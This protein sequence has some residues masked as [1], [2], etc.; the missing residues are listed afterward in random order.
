VAL[1]PVHGYAIAPPQDLKT[2]KRNARERNRV[3]TVNQSFETLR[4]AVPSAAAHRKLSKVNIVQQAMEYIHSLVQLLQEAEMTSHGSPR[5]SGASSPTCLSSPV[6]CWSF[7]SS[8]PQSPEGIRLVSSSLSED[9]MQHRVIQ[10]FNS[11]PSPDGYGTKL[12][13]SSKNSCQQYNDVCCRL[14]DAGCVLLD[15]RCR[16]RNDD[17]C[18]LPDVQCHPRDESCYSPD[19]LGCSSDDSCPVPVISCR[20]PDDSCPVPVI[21]CRPPDDSCPVPVKSCRPPDDS[22]LQP[23]IRSS[24]A[25]EKEDDVLNVI[26]DWQFS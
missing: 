6:P 5:G 13:K 7:Q 16:P 26:M 2:M 23:S 10:C 22:C 19:I 1:H 25:P 4:R 12:D 24:G 21:S 17:T 9:C 3:L 11:L 8:Y 20:P 18:I 15:V 14:Q